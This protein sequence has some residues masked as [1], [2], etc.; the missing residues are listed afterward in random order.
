[1]RRLEYQARND[2]KNAKELEI[3]K[4]RFARI[5]QCGWQVWLGV[6]RLTHVCGSMSKIREGNADDS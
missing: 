1:M 5:V 6:F 3:I 4:A 2:K